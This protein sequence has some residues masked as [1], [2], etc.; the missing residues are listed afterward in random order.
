VSGQRLEAR[1]PPGYRNSGRMQTFFVPGGIQPEQVIEVPVDV[2][3]QYDESP[4]SL[5]IARSQNGP[6]EPKQRISRPGCC[7]MCALCVGR[8]QNYFLIPIFI[9][10]IISLCLS[11]AVVVRFTPLLLR[12]V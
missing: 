12:F 4:S 11:A 8:N 5:S 2:A 10:A 7:G 6:M 1:I 3:L 9:F